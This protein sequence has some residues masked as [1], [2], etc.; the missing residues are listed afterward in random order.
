MEQAGGS[1]TTGLERLLDAVPTVLHTRVAVAFGSS[2]DVEAYRR[3]HADAIT[4]AIADADGRCAPL[5]LPSAASRKRSVA[6][7]TRGGALFGP[8]ED[9]AGSAT[10]AALA[11]SAAV[12]AKPSNGPPS[13]AA[14]GA[15]GDAHAGGE[16]EKGDHEARLRDAR[17]AAYALLGNLPWCAADEQPRATHL[18]PRAAAETA[19]AMGPSTTAAATA[20]V[21]AAAAAAD[22]DVPWYAAEMCGW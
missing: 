15:A 7:S 12:A 4:D 5:D 18:A 11:A 1:C 8:A 20:A 2:A 9:A 13:M 19:V 17:H 21:A 14:G 16:E 6:S 3:A 10:R 22:D